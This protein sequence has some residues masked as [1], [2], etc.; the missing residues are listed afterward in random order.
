MACDAARVNWEST[1]K[2]KTNVRAGSGP[3]RKVG[4]GISLLA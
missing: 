1:M 4:V 2:I 3:C